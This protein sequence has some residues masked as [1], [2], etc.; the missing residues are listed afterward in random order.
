MENKLK[1]AIRRL[2]ELPPSK[3]NPAVIFQ[4]KRWLFPRIIAY[5]DGYREEKTE[6]TEQSQEEMVDEVFKE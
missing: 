4:V 2:D 6:K 5:M 1:E 3:W